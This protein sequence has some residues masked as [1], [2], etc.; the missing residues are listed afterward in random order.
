MP[1]GFDNAKRILKRRVSNI[2]LGFAKSLKKRKEKKK[3]R[4]KKRKVKKRKEQK[5]KEKKRGR[6]KKMKEDEG[7]R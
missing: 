3:K 2:F 4:E 1:L 5:R 6:K 7:L